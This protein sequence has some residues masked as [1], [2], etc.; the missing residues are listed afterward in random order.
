MPAKPII[1]KKTRFNDL[2]DA[3]DD[4]QKPSA[5]PKPSTS[6]KHVRILPPHDHAADSDPLRNE[7]PAFPAFYRVSHNEGAS[8]YNNGEAVSFVIRLL[9]VIK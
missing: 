9:K 8:V 3:S 4:D 5:K 7:R 2:G 6:E 1:K